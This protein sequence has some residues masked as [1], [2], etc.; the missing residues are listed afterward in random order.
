MLINMVKSKISKSNWMQQ[1]RVPASENVS[2]WRSTGNLSCLW[3]GMCRHQCWSLLQCLLT[4]WCSHFVGD[5][6]RHCALIIHAYWNNHLL[7]AVLYITRILK[8]HILK[9]CPHMEQPLLQNDNA[10]PYKTAVTDPQAWPLFSL[11]WHSLFPKQRNM[12]SS[13]SIIK[14]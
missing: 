8:A 11:I 7:W 10:W 6:K 2:N 9:A 14:L 4:K 13:G 5:V 3:W 12:R 1:Q